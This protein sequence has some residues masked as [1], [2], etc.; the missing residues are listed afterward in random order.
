[1][2]HV[3]RVSTCRFVLILLFRRQYL[4][5]HVGLEGLNVGV[6]SVTRLAGRFSNFS[7]L[8]YQQ[9]NTLAV[10]FLESIGPCQVQ[11]GDYVS[12]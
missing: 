11:N 8:V 6:V 3:H 5:H 10:A 2:G 7:V 1:M 4:T 9:S 12:P